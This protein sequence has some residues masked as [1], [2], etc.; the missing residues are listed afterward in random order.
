MCTIQSRFLRAVPGRLSIK[1]N[2]AIVFGVGINNSGMASVDHSTI[3]ANVSHSDGD[4]IYSDNKAN[5]NS[6]CIANNFNYMANV[7]NPTTVNT[8]ADYFSI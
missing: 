3:I 8:V 7:Y 5:S 2:T 6:S 4:G 1:N